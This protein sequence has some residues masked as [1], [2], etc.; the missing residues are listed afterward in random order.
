MRIRAGGGIELE[1]ISSRLH[2]ECGVPHGAGS[3]NRKII[4][5]AQTKSWWLNGLSDAGAPD[6]YFLNTTLDY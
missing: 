6:L 3:H 4:T 1:R 5:G 2:A